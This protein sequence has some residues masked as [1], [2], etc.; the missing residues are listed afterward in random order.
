MFTSLME[1][2]SLVIN[3]EMLGSTQINS[4]WDDKRKAILLDAYALRDK[5]KT[6]NIK[7]EYWPCRTRQAGI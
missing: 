4:T 6:I 1:I 7:G 3:N 2:D 5:L